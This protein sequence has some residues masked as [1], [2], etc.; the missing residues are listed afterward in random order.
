MKFLGVDYGT[1]RIGLATGDMEMSFAFPLRSVTVTSD[2]DAV[3][4]VADAVRAEGADAVVVGAPYRLSGGAGEAP[5]ETEAAVTAFVDGLRAVLG[6]PV[7]TEDERF[8][9][10][11]ADRLRREAGTSAKKFD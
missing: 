6:V 5:G 3:A 7:E 9:S 10:A 4:A 11:V 1:K 8:T 2:E